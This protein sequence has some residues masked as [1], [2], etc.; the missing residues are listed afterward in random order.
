[1]WIVVWDN[2]AQQ[3][4][5]NEKELE[6]CITHTLSKGAPAEVALT[7]IEAHPSATRL[8]RNAAIHQP[9]SPLCIRLC[10]LIDIRQSGGVNS[11]SSAL[12]GVPSLHS[13]H[14]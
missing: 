6:A 2:P 11:Q 8:T 4:L 3:R 10:A 13:P 5:G 14:A 7:V 9:P 12:R 1:M